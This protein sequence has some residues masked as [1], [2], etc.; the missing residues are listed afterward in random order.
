MRGEG[1][2]IVFIA[3]IAEATK[4]SKDHD[5]RALATHP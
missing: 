4:I 3:K 5:F 1:A 2:K